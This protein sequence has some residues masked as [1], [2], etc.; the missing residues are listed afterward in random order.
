L[1]GAAGEIYNPSDIQRVGE[2]FENPQFFIDG[3][4]AADLVQGAIGDCWFISALATMATKQ[5]LVERFC[6]A[7][8]EQVGVYGFIFFR[9]AAWVS[10][11]IDE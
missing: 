6:V 10:V 2:I 8:D 7:K 3:A 9:D 1:N 11:I 5:D 4:D